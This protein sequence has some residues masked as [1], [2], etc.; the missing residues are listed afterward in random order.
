MTQKP[1]NVSLEQSP[2]NHPVGF[3]NGLVLGVILG[4]TGYFLLG[5]EKGKEIK[6][7]LLEVAKKYWE[8]LEEEVETLKNKKEQVA[9][10]VEESAKTVQ[11]EVK[12]QLPQI[13]KEIKKEIKQLEDSV[14]DAQKKADEMQMQLSQAASKIEKKFFFRKGRILKK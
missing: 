8:D 5:T 6:Q 13:K 1:E 2:Q 11:D 3:T 10:K 9:H 7:D 4:A 12:T 14:A